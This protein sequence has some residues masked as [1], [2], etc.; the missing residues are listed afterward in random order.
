[1]HL[2]FLISNLELFKCLKLNLNTQDHTDKYS[3]VCE[4]GRDRER[5]VEREREGRR[6]N[7]SKVI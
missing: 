4:R 1:M 7:E 6:D 5:E 3:T 2:F